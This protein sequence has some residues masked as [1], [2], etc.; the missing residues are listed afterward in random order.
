MKGALVY[1][2]SVFIIIIV[3]LIVLLVKGSITET[4]SIKETCIKTE[5]YAADK[6]VFKPVY[7]CSQLTKESN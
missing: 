3:F 7:D 6:G 4:E 1:L 5:L 2:V